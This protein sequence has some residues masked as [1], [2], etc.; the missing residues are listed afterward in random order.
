MSD[1]EEI[2]DPNDFDEEENLY[3]YDKPLRFDPLTDDLQPVEIEEGMFGEFLEGIQDYN[4]G[5]LNYI[6]EARARG[7]ITDTEA[8]ILWDHESVDLEGMK[9]ETTKFEE[10]LNAKAERILARRESGELSDFQTGVKL[11][12][13]AEKKQKF[14]RKLSF[15]SVGLSMEDIIDTAD[16]ASHIIEDTY[17]PEGRQK[18]KQLKKLLQSVPPEDRKVLIDNLL[19]NG[20]ID[21][22]QYSYLCT[23]FL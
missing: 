19:E 5:L 9:V 3:D 17:D 15:L 13:L 6:Q 11:A 2:Y 4:E 12:D 1:H 22:A 7:E 18:R 21:E 20:E 10:M 16:D 23:E 8:D 14:E